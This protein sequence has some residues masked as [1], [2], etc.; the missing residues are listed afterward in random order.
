MDASPR[1]RD[2]LLNIQIAYVEMPQL[3]LTERQ[4]QRLWRLSR[5]DCDAALGTLLMKGFL[6]QD[7]LGS[8]IRPS[9]KRGMAAGW[10]ATSRA[11]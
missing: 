11:S 8:Y 1:V 5:E 6:R 7:P 4:V 3:T 10:T 9:A 2:A